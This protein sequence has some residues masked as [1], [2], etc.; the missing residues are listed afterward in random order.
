M[1]KGAQMDPRIFLAGACRT[2]I[3]AFQGGFADVPATQLGSV[4]LRAS[5][6]RAGIAPEAFTEVILGNVLSAGLG[7]NPARQAAIG[8]GIPYTSGAFTV[9]KV[10]GSGLTAVVLAIQAIRCGEASVLAAGGMEN[11]T[12][13]PYLLERARSGYRLGDGVL[14]DALMRDGLCD[15]YESVP[16]GVFADRCASSLGFT[17]GQQDDYAVASYQR[18]Q[19]A[20]REGA[21]LGEIVPVSAH[22][23]K[24]P[25]EVCEDEEPN[26]FQEAKLR[27]LKPAFSSDGTVTAG[28]A[29]SISDGAASLVVA[30]EEACQAVGMTMQARVLGYAFSSREPEWFTL[31]PID[32][33]S[34]LLRALSLDAASVDLF[35][36]NEAFAVVPL[37]AMAHLDIP[38]EKVDI[39]GGAIALGHPIGAS[40]ARILVTLIHALHRTRARI[41]IAS[42]C[43]GGGE[44][45]AIAVENADL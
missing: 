25:V 22:R 28:N 35:E 31:A 12:R 41:G 29:S 40:A 6:D 17:R 14:V 16:M 37:A 30:S 38:H 19:A 36:I 26:V 39:H 9:N 45:V 1:K 32:A 8:A 4:A 5:L 33:I 11:M 2:P 42:L 20:M 10:C 44:A 24:A 13:A 23:G 21:F 7:Q 15:A 27:G 3:G 34:K 18:A 43:I